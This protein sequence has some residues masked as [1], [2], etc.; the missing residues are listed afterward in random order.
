MKG[1][2]SRLLLV[3]MLVSVTACSQ[4]AKPVSEETKAP[5]AAQP[6]PATPAP[7]NE[8]LKIGVVVPLTQAGAIVG[9]SQRYGS[10][11]AVEEIN[12]KGGIKGRKIELII[13]DTQLS[14]P[15]A[16]NAM[17]KVLSQKP[18][19]VMASVLGTQMMAMEPSIKEAGIPVL[20][21]SGTR[22]VTQMGNS[23]I[24][25]YFPHD[26]IAKV[27]QTKFAIEHLKTKKPAL[28]FLSDEYGQ[29]G[30]DI[31]VKALQDAGIKPVALES[32]APTDKDM[33]AQLLNIQ[34]AG[35]DVILSQLHADTVAVMV[36][37]MEKLGI[38]IP[39]VAANALTLP[40]ALA[41]VTASSVKGHY[42]E[43]AIVPG[44]SNDPL[45]KE[46]IKKFET[47]FNRK[48]DAFA[49]L[50]Y[51]MMMMLAK[52]VEQ[53]GTDPKAVANALRAIKHDGLVTTYEI[54]A[55]GNANHQSI[56]YQFEDGQ[57]LKEMARIQVPVSK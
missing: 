12:A 7:S 42:V 47:K 37:Q 21:P 4:P 15:V 24:F 16:V 32:V 50:H 20:T 56:I 5:P 44:I 45:V 2:L 36:Q 1:I 18:V 48:A 27:A 52:A 30:R 17:S 43:T 28:L 23:W 54:D 46:F 19:A 31:M 22:K 13:E 9:L 11:M 33:T 3:S 39:H 29:S 53:A 10:E 41:L 35:A 57:Q 38:Q 49:L 26:G 51:D 55:E 40:S 14:N 34:K 6:S 8:P 25:R